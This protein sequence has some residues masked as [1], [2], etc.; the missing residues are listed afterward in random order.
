MT[1]APAQ[2]FDT[3][4]EIKYDKSGRAVMVTTYCVVN[5]Y[6][7]ANSDTKIRPDGTYTESCFDEH[8]GI[9]RTNEP[10]SRARLE[11]LDRHN[12]RSISLITV[13]GTDRA[14]VER[15][16]AERKITARHIN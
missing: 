2:E 1:I 14:T 10:V 3:T 13:L 9:C 4:P 15:H 11:E 8:H 6:S 16:L 7:L 12:P 5:G